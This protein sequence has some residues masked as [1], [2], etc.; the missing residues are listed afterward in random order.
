[1]QVYPFRIFPLIVPLLLGFAVVAE[2]A[3]RLDGSPRRFRLG[4]VVGA[5]L[6]LL[7][8]HPMTVVEQ[9]ADLARPPQLFLRQP[10]P[11]KAERDPAVADWRAALRY[12][13]DSTPP[14]A[15][16]LLSPSDRNSFF[17]SRRAAVVNFWAVRV[18]RVGSW[19]SRVQDLWGPL[20]PSH[21]FNP[22]RGDAHFDSLSTETVLTLARR[23]NTSFL[24]THG[25]YPFPL[26]FSANQTRVYALPSP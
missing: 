12:L 2:L 19:W 17:F 21:P 23:Y 10:L 25:T 5:T 6:A 14:D 22:K 1:M 18:D 3:P 8:A 7:L 24:V 26:P 15:I 16:V 4:V 9:D 11:G 13:R 20:S